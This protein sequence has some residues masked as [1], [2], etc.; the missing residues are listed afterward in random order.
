MHGSLNE[1]V[2]NELFVATVFKYDVVMLCESWSNEL[3]D[4]DVKGYVR[5]SKTRKSKKTAK[6]SSGGLEVYI[7]E[8][9]FKGIRVL[10]WDFEDGLNFEFNNDF[11][12]W[13]KPLYLFFVYFK[14]KNS[15]REDLD[16][17]DDCFNVLLN[18]IANVADDGNVL[19]SGDLNSRVS[20]INECNIDIYLW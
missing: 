19:I 1:K 12:G 11:F 16:N 18:Q 14:P 8:H 17:D 5:I 13:E 6:R 2:K 9:L 7:R 10:D 3:S 4:I 15:T 20:N